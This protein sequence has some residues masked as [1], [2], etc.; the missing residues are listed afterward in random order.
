MDPVLIVLVVAL[1]LALGW[2]LW[3][4]RTE[5]PARTDAGA[6]ERPTDEARAPS[7]EAPRPRPSPPRAEPERPA[8]A[9][10]I[11]RP[12]VGETVEARR[13]VDRESDRERIRRGLAK[14]RGGFVARLA[15]LL[16]GQPKLDEALRERIEEVLFTADIGANAAETLMTKVGELLERK[17]A[18]DADAVWA[19]LEQAALGLVDLPASPPD[20]TPALRP[21]VLLVI[22]VNGAGKTTTLGKLAAAHTRAGRKVLLVAGDTFRA[23]AVD[24]LEVWARR[25]GCPIHMGSGKADP[26]SVVYEGIARGRREGFDVVLCDTAGRLH[27]RK[28][29]MDELGKVR[30]AAA[31]ALGAELPPAERDAVVGPHDTYLVLDATIG[32]NALAQA[33][34]FKETTDFTGLVVTKL[35]GTAKGGVALGVCDELRIPI[36]YIG[37]GEGIEDLRPFD[38]SDF[39][40]ALFADRERASEEA[41]A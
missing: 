34:L 2:W 35:D 30:R 14:T 16:R 10:P 41:E 33:R 39:V 15:R 7:S 26:S 18:S 11:D 1:A 31:K 38:A 28:E 9:L 12:G 27:T 32:Q 24:Q 4:R 19:A 37:V 13:H 29:L 40:A 36:R 8:V 5:P 22:G 6:D 3:T 21:Y 17:Q 25:V 23:G 20:F